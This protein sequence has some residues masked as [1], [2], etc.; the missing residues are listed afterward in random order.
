MA[1]KKELMSDQ[2]GVQTGRSDLVIRLGCRQEGVM[3]EVVLLGKKAFE[4]SLAIA[5][6]SQGK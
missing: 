5:G 3:K 6:G 4:E 2:V 1:T